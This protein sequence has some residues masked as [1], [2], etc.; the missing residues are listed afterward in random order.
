MAN[1]SPREAALRCPGSSPAAAASP[2]PAVSEEGGV[3]REGARQAEILAGQHAVHA[4]RQRLGVGR[5]PG[6]GG[7]QDHLPA[8][9]RRELRLQPR[10]ALLRTARAPQLLLQ[11]H[12]GHLRQSTATGQLLPHTGIT[13]LLSEQRQKWGTRLEASCVHRAKR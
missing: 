7:A 1:P 5:G 3:G 10:P 9:G 6:H 12:G 8:R 4:L 11:R 13:K 2:G